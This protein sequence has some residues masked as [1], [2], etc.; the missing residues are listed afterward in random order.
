M[1]LGP[2]VASSKSGSKKPISSAFHSHPAAGLILVPVP[3][4]F[5]GSLLGGALEMPAINAWR[6]AYCSAEN[7]VPLWLAMS[8]IWEQGGLPGISSVWLECAVPG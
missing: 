1:E 8:L 4:V 3:G 5:A 6:A 7:L 2:E